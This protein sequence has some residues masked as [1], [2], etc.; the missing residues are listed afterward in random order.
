MHHACAF[1]VSRCFASFTEKNC[2]WTATINAA[3]VTE[4]PVLKVKLSGIE[5]QWHG[6]P[7]ESTSPS[8]S[9]ES[10]SKSS[11]PELILLLL[12]FPAQPTQAACEQTKQCVH[13]WRPRSVH[14]CDISA[15]TSRQNRCYRSSCFWQLAQRTEPCQRM[16]H[17]A[18]STASR[19]SRCWERKKRHHQTS[20]ILWSN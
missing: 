16:I 18:N 7:G 11:R 17:S 20:T 10:S 3:Y 15:C 13:A 6:E 9:S 1:D 2:P 19:R 14:L 4:S 8:W 5:M 12:Q